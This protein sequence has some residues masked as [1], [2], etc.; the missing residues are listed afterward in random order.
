[1]IGTFLIVVAFFWYVMF[2]IVMP[3]RWGALQAMSLMTPN[4]S[5]DT[6]FTYSDLFMTNIWK[7]LLVFGVI[8]LAMWAFTY[9]QEKG[10]Q[11]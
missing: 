2:E 7:F 10:K 6:V 9:S 1:V 8:G 11:I 3:V 4:N 5:T